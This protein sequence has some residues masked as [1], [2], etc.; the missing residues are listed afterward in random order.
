MLRRDGLK[1]PTG[2]VNSNGLRPTILPSSILPLLAGTKEK[3]R[4]NG[5]DHNLFISS[6][7]I[8]VIIAYMGITHITWI[9]QGYCRP[10]NG[11]DLVR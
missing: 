3:Q 6:Y 4:A 10:K 5:A 1:G 11:F 7:S 2:H 9:K 8:E